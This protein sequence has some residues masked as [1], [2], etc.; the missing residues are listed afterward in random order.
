LALKKFSIAKIVGKL[1]EKVGKYDPDFIGRDYFP[2]WYYEKGL[3][4]R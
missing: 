2:Q 4:E 3:T 1:M